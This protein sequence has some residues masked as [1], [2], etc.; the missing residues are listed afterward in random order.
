MYLPDGLLPCTADPL[1]LNLFVLSFNSYSLIVPFSL[2]FSWYFLIN[3]SKLSKQS[4]KDSLCRSTSSGF[5][6]SVLTSQVQK[7]GSLPLRLPTEFKFISPVYPCFARPCLSYI[8]KDNS[9]Y[10]LTQVSLGTP[11]QIQ[12]SVHM[13]LFIDLA[14]SASIST[15]SQ[16][17]SFMLASVNIISIF[18]VSYFPSK[19]FQHSRFINSSLN[20]SLIATIVDPS[21]KKTNVTTTNM[22]KLRNTYHLEQI[23]P[24]V[25]FPNLA[26][27]SAVILQSTTQKEIR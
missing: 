2:I 13:K 10:S 3:Y 11:G 6:A 22:M 5:G 12:K 20:Q 19:A 23:P 21:M 7:S 1:L 17:N 18:I 15:M 9:L 16:N 4:M 26:Q 8:S 27:Q 24:N 25:L 14:I